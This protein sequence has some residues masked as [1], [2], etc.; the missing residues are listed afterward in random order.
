MSCN[1]RTNRIPIKWVNNNGWIDIFVIKTTTFFFGYFWHISLCFYSNFDWESSLDAELNFTSNEYPL[2]ILLIDP[3]TP[4]TRNTWKNRMMMSSFQFLR[5]FLF[6][7]YWGLSKLCWVGTRWTRNLIPHPTSSPD[8]NFSKNIGRYVKN[9]NKKVVFFFSSSKINKYYFI[10]LTIMLLIFLGG[11]FWV[12]IS[13]NEHDISAPKLHFL[14]MVN[15]AF[16]K[17]EALVC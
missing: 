1:S 14:K 9:T 17:W 8:R 7:G 15:G 4:K 16:I 2:G 13:S 3:S 5:Y 12:E 6:L 11:P 10:I